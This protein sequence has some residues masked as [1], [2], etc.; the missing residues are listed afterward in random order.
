MRKEKPQHRL[1][2]E[3][4]QGLECLCFAYICFLTI[5]IYIYNSTV[6][7]SPVGSE[8]SFHIFLQIDMHFKVLES[9]LQDILHSVDNSLFV[10]KFVLRVKI[11]SKF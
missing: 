5:D 1:L 7:T 4:A 2:F 6:Y 10:Q 8:V 9:T 11:Q 3:G